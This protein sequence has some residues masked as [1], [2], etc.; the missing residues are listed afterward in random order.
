LIRF[1]P[2][3]AA[4]SLC[5]TLTACGTFIGFPGVYRIDIEQGNLVTQ[6]MIE[7]LQPGMSKRQVRFIM[8]SPLI[9][10][11]FNAARWEYPYVIRNG[12]TIIREAQVT[13]LFE[14]DA[15]AEIRGDYLPAWA[16][17]AA[18]EETEAESGETAQ[19]EQQSED[20]SEEQ[21]EAQS[22]PQPDS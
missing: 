7:Q 22:Q 3:A 21:S 10:D 20:Q 5:L 8:G 18:G 4:V 6:D 13:I 19:P 16:K 15:L 2:L 12:Q 14:G 17:P 9:E 1:T 11:T